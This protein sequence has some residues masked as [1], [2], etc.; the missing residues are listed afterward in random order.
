MSY[1][2]SRIIGRSESPNFVHKPLVLVRR[3]L[4]ICVPRRQ[5]PKRLIDVLKSFH[6][7][8]ALSVAPTDR[9]SLFEIGHFLTGRIRTVCTALD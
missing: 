9:L 1:V 5:Q 6:I 8:H 4:A 7:A 3:F 2:L